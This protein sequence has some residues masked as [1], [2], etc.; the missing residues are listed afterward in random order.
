M[1][2]RPADRV[3]ADEAVF[4][5]ARLAR[6]GLPVAGL[7]AALVVGGIVGAGV[8]AAAV[9]PEP[10]VAPVARPDP[11]PNLD[12]AEVVEAPWRREPGGDGEPGPA[13]PRGLLVVDARTSGRHLFVNGD[14]FTRDAV[15]VVVSVG[16]ASNTAMEIRSV[17]MPGGSTAFRTGANDRFA[18]AFDIEGWP[19]TPTGWLV[20]NA[21]N[22]FGYRIESVRQDILL[23]SDHGRWRAGAHLSP[24]DSD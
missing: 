15:V 18:L 5:P 11:T 19:A 21:Y 17:A 22:Q 10:S 1:D 7:A 8:L 13:R 23:S 16:D 9:A 14:V 6:G 4:V 12:L 24:G 20:A 3:E 2:D